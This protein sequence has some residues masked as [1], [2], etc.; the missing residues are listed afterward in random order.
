VIIKPPPL[1]PGDTIGI[2]APAGPVSRE[3]IQPAIDL[4][5]ERGFHALLSLNLF[6]KKGYLAGHDE[7]RLED[8]H[9]MF[10]DSS[11]KAILCARGGFGTIRLLDRIDYDLVRGNPKVVAGYSDITALLFA[12]F[13][14]TGLITF[15]GPV[16]RNL[17]SDPLDNLGF[18]LETTSS[19]EPRA[20]DLSGGTWLKRGRAEGMVIGGNLSLVCSLIGTPYLPDLTGAILFIEDTNEPLYRIDRMLTH[21]RLSGIISNLAGLI[22]GDFKDCGEPEKIRSLLSEATHG[23]NIPVVDGL[24]VGH[25]TRNRT[26]PMGISAELDTRKMRLTFLETPIAR[27]DLPIV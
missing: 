20:I 13:K 8:F 27:P 17:A 26:I 19:G 1:T 2:I 21:L 9:A 7:A 10:A 11:V 24:P 18:L 15:H 23:I 25:G 16:L 4:L 5:K 6:K 3:E 22:A 12:L 14:E